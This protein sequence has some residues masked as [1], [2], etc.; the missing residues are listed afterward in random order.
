MLTP[1]TSRSNT[2][3]NSH[4]TP[5]VEREGATAKRPGRPCTGT[6][7]KL[8]CCGKCFPTSRSEPGVSVPTP[9]TKCS[10]TTPAPLV[11]CPAEPSSQA[12]PGKRTG[13]GSGKRQHGSDLIPN[14]EREGATAK[15]PGR[16]CTGTKAKLPCCGK[17][18]P[19][20]RS[21]WCIG[22]HSRDQMQQNHSRAT[23]ALSCRA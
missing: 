3:M 10:K 16:P 9:K 17:C 23:G 15:R 18:F 2:R 4:P 14:V 11:L 13:V 20:S 22:S 21:A 5:V 12:S 8:P 1:C 7:A 6:K 19:T